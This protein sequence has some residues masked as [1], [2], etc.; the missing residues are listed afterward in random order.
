MRF[1][2]PMLDV[3]ASNKDLADFDPED[4]NLPD[5]ETKDGEA[6]DAWLVRVQVTRDTARGVWEV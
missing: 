1:L 2:H 4:P 3:E 6:R 5:E